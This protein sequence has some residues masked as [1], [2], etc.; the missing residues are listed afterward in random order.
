MTRL[1]KAERKRLTELAHRQELEAERSSFPF[2]VADLRALLDYLDANLS[3]C[4]H[5][6]ALTKAYLDV[7]GLDSTSILSWLQE[8]GGFCDCEMFNIEDL[9]L[10]LEQ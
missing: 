4:D 1:D 6:P 9:L 8:H 3:E 2:S 7:K 10:D 5:T